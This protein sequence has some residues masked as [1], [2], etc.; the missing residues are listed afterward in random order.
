MASKQR[1][2]CGLSV[3]AVWLAVIF[4]LP[5]GVLATLVGLSAGVCLYE[6]CAML[7]KGGYALPMPELMGATLLWFLCSYFGGLPKLPLFTVICAALFFRVLLDSRIEKPMET[8]ALTVVSFLYVPVSLSYFIGLVR[9]APTIA[10]GIFFAFFLVLVTKMSDTG[11]YFVGSAI[12]KHKMCPRLS[13]G[14]SWEGTAGGYAFSLVTA[15][16]VV[17][18]AHLMPNADVLAMVRNLTSSLGAG[19]WFFVSIAILVTVGICGD[20][21]ESLFKRQCGVKDS[22]ALFPAMGGFFDTFDSIIF[23]PA[24]MLFLMAIAKTFL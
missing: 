19:I 21:L 23:I 8:A 5:F 22:S 2:I 18:C 15:A 14:K 10:S 12:G 11:G 6:L 3:A 17:T 4:L 16:I 7:K 1:V 9:T 20:L 24:T 13:P